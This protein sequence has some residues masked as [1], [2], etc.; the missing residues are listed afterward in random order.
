[1]LLKMRTSEKGHPYKG[2]HRIAP[3]MTIERVWFPSPT[4]TQLPSLALNAWSGVEESHSSTQRSVQ[5]ACWLAPPLSDPSPR[6][7]C[8]RNG[9]I[10]GIGVC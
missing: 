8:K 5:G 9:E 6:T 1:M 4:E 10:L 2:V 3:F 7:S